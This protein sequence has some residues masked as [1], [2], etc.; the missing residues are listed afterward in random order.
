VPVSAV[1][2]WR[3]RVFVGVSLDG[4]IA[5]PDSDLDWLDAPSEIAHEQ[6][7]SDRRALEWDTFRPNIDHFVMGRGTYEKALTFDRWPYPDEQVLLLS[8]T[9]PASAD[10][11]VTVV[12]SVE[13]AV[14]LLEERNAREVYVDGGITVQ[15]FLEADLIDEITIAVAPVLIGAGIPLFGALSHD[16]QLRLTGTHAGDGGMTHATYSVVR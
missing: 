4:F 14:K 3:G 8:K 13:D 7:V 16:I 15:A 11:R 2:A 12:R 6:I 9:A 5:R 1:R 10:P